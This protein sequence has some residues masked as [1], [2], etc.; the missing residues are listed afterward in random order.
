[1]IEKTLQNVSPTSSQSGTDVL[2]SIYIGRSTGG[3]G[4]SAQFLFQSNLE[5]LYPQMSPIQLQ[6]QLVRTLRLS[7]VMMIHMDTLSMN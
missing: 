7:P 5:W 6:Q 3:L 4:L 2:L 1:M